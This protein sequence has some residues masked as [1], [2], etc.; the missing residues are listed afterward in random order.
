MK[1]TENII[2]PTD[3]FLLWLH[4]CALLA[5]TSQGTLRLQKLLRKGT[6]KTQKV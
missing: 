4:N 2:I 1:T 6:K 3:K 5:L